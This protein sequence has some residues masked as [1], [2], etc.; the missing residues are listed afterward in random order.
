MREEGVRGLFHGL[1]AN[2]LRGMGG[3]LLLVGY[4]EAKKFLRA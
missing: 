3:A 1:T 4:D 2:L